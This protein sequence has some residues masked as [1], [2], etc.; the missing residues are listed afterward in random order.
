MGNIFSIDNR[1]KF[2]VLENFMFRTTDRIVIEPYQSTK[3]FMTY[4]DD[5]LRTDYLP[6]NLH[7]VEISKNWRVLG[8]ELMSYY[9]H[10]KNK[11]ELVIFNNS[12]YQITIRKNQFFASIEYTYPNL[13]RYN[14]IESMETHL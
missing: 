6:S 14:Q 1:D 4:G 7:T 5:P 12:L 9:K 8:L 13:S 3:L 11:F 2:V 10:P